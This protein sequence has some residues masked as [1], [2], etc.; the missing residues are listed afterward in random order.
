MPELTDLFARLTIALQHEAVPARA[1]VRA[2][3]VVA[4]LVARFVLLALVHVQLAVLAGEAGRTGA[5]VRCG[6][7]ATV[8]ARRL[9]NGCNG[10]IS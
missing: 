4:G 6:A 2:F 7:A 1:V 8:P 10:S 5:T 9:T 3:R